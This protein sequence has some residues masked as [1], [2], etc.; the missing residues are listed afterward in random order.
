VG[1]FLP[2]GFAAMRLAARIVVQWR[3]GEA[4][5][6]V[7]C[8]TQLDDAASFCSRCGSAT[9]IAPPAYAP[10][11]ASVPKPQMPPNQ[12]P[13]IAQGYKEPGIALLLSIVFPGAGQF[14][15][16]HIGKGIVVLLTFWLLIPYI[17]SLFDA[18]RSAKRI[19]QFG[20]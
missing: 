9:T 1:R 4:M 3:S 16:G 6:C 2:V 18:F 15:N 17:W 5:F 11:P 12:R 13:V 19:N 20:Y 7:K 14:Y 8:G 10:L